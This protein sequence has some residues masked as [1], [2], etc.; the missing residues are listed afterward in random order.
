MRLSV[1]TLAVIAAPSATITAQ[2]PFHL[3]GK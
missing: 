3:D 1:P 2:P